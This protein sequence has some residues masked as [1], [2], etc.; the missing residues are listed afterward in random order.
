MQASPVTA[1]GRRH[2]RSRPVR[3]RLLPEYVAG[4]LGQEHAADHKLCGLGVIE[5][6]ASQPGETGLITCRRDDIRSGYQVIEVH[7]ADHF[8]IVE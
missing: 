7:L 4:F 1:D 2:Q 3:R 5:A 8:G 6:V